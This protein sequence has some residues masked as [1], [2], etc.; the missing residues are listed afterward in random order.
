MTALA[1]LTC[2]LA[3]GGM[4]PAHAAAATTAGTSY[5]LALGDSLSQGVQPTA[6]A[7]LFETNRGYVDDLYAAERVTHPG[8][9]LSKLGCPGE[10]TTTMIAGGICP[11]AHGSQ[12]AEAAAFLATHRVALVTID[13]GANDVDSCVAASGIDS[14]CIAA[15]FGSAASNLPVILTTLRTAAP[16]VPIYAM[17]YY[18]PF[19][20]AWLAGQQSLARESACLTTGVGYGTFCGAPLPPTGFD[21]LL[22]TVYAAFGVPVADVAGAFQTNNFSPVLVVGPPVNVTLVCAWTWAC[23][24]FHNVHANDAG[25][26]VIALTF[27]AAIESSE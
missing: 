1:L 20:A 18:D 11:Y 9:Q 4:R 7:P 3:A 22:G 25:Y 23:S 12:L 2:A 17:N 6:A 27:E 13:I 19:L 26:A 5:Y 10:T 14:A 24:S 16:G 21:G 8:L 15:G